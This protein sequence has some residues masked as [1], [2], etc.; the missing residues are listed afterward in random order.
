MSSETAGDVHLASISL[1]YGA[2]RLKLPLTING[3]MM[4]MVIVISGDNDGNDDD[5]DDDCDDY[6]DD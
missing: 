2:D 1:I 6:D 4:M 5:G 3:K